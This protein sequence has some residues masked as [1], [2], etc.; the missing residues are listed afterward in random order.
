MKIKEMLLLAAAGL[1]LIGCGKPGGDANTLLIGEYVSLSG[2]TATFGQSMRNAIDIAVDEVNGGGGLLGCQIKLIVEDDQSK[3]EQ[4]VTAVLKLIQRDRVTAILGEVTSSC[5]IAAAPI[6]QQNRIPM[7][8]PSSTSPELTRKGDY[9]FRTCFIDPFQGAA[10]ARFASQSLKAK[11]AAVFT[12]RKQD[13]SVGLAQ[14]FKQTFQETGGKI[15]AD[16]AYQSDD[17]EFRPQLTAIRAAK[18][19]VIFVPGYYTQCVLIAKQARELG[20][21]QPF[22]GGDGWDSDVTLKSG[23][24]A[25]EPCYFS[26]HYSP[27]DPRPEVQAFVEK[28]R[29]RFGVTPDAL[30]VTGYDGAHVLFDAIRRANST[31]GAA[32]RDALAQTRDF[33]GVS[34]R[35]TID[36]NRNA[37]KELVVLKIED[38][39]FKFVESVKP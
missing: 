15:V 9:I 37:S 29:K 10:M 36:A 34:S 26:N 38:G 39:K 23:G 7:V 35:I 5:S 21:T 27:E 4:A 1:G 20:L 25:V 22:L 24:K 13:Y 12:D 31:D 17:S 16:E 32:I 11:T 2:N 18:P 3:P 14:F 19:E 30:A 6:C 28:Y 8:S 33:K